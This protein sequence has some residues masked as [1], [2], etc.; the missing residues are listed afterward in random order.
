MVLS[1]DSKV[2]FSPDF[3]DSTALVF[4]VHE[5]IIEGLRSNSVTIKCDAKG[6]S[7]LCDGERTYRIRM[8]ENSNTQYVVESSEKE[9]YLRS[10]FPGIISLDPIYCSCVPD[11]DIEIAFN[12]YRDSADV[13][14]L[15]A[16]ETIWSEPKILS[17]MRSN[18]LYYMLE[19]RWH[20]LPRNMFFLYMD[21]VLKTCAIVGKSGDCPDRY[22]S[23]EVWT[24]M[25]DILRSESETDMEFDNTFAELPL[26]LVQYL[27]SRLSPCE[28]TEYKNKGESEWPLHIPVDRT[29]VVCFRAQQILEARFGSNNRMPINVSKFVDDIRDVLMT[30]ASVDP[31]LL[32]DDNSLSIQIPKLIEGYGTVDGDLVLAFDPSI[33]S[34]DL[35]KRIAEL[36]K[37]KPRWLKDEFE[38]HISSILAPDAK[39]ES[40]LMKSCRIEQDDDGKTYYSSKF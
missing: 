34:I 28:G 7:F 3:T 35:D 1:I 17:H 39:P 23:E 11:S 10:S 40:I 31:R 33:L 18:R 14:R 20:R 9:S 30:T 25:N 12:K 13:T 26:S 15:I 8:V 37:V 21:V 24:R 19:N 5:S 22:N 27:L 4:S 6:V 16:N 36:F 32:H 38:G 29:K 2:K